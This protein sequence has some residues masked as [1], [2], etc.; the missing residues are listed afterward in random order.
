MRL[1]GIFLVSHISAAILSPMFVYGSG[2]RNILRQLKSKLDIFIPLFF[3]S[4]ILCSEAC[5][6]MKFV[7]SFTAMIVTRLQVSS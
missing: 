1:K 3:G 7:D 4:Y 5:V 6:Y 2:R